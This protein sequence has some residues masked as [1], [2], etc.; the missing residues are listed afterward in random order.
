MENYRRLERESQKDKDIHTSSFKRITLG[1]KTPKNISQFNSESFMTNG[2][3]AE[4]VLIEHKE[5]DNV[6]KCKIEIPKLKISKST[7]NIKSFISPRLP[8]SPQISEKE[9]L[10][11]SVKKSIDQNPK[12]MER[13]ITNKPSISKQPDS[14]KKGKTV[15]N[16]LSK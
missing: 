4:S 2:R 14:N 1:K 3:I 5:D 11:L 16:S 8:K 15:K 9:N 6:Q 10:I 7:K 12:K 13:S